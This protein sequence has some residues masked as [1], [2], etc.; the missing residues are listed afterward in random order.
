MPFTLIKTIPD[1]NNLLGGVRNKGKFAEGWCFEVQTMINS[2]GQLFQMTDKEPYPL[3]GIEKIWYICADT[4]KVK[5]QFMNVIIKL[6]LKL[7]H[8]LG[9]WYNSALPPKKETVA[10][11]VSNTP[12][13]VGNILDGYW[14]LLQD[15]STCSGYQYK[16]LMC[17]PPKPGG[18]AC[19]GEAMRKKKC[20]E[21]P[22]PNLGEEES[23][24]K[25]KMNP[26]VI[27][28]MPISVRP[29][30][31][32]KCHLKESDTIYTAFKPGVGI[33]EN[34]MKVPSRIVM[35][36][37]SISI[38]TD[39]DLA[40]ELGTYILD[41]S[42]LKTIE[43][44]TNCFILESGEAK[45]KL[46][47]M[48]T[49][50]NYSQFVEEWKYDFNLFKAQCRKSKDKVAIDGAD[51]NA[52]NNELNKKVQA[53][54]LDVMK[55]KTKKIQIKAKENPINKVEKMEET[56]MIAVKKELDID[57]LLEKEELERE[58]S[59]QDEL[60]ASITK[61]RQKDECLIKSIKEK[62]LEDQFNME[63]FE[64]DKEV[65]T[66][67]EHAKKDILQKRNQ[68]KIKILN[69]RRR[70][71]RKKKLLND[72]LSNMR[73]DMAGNL[74]NMNK[75]GDSSQ[76]FK[77]TPKNPEDTKK[78]SAYCDK[79]FASASPVQYKECISEDTFCFVCCS[80]EIGEA[81]VR[82]REQCN[83]KCDPP[84]ED[85]LPTKGSWQWVQ[86]TNKNT[87]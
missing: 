26:P 10:D 55:E 44:D 15:W 62:E 71:E 35:N 68:V 17:V 34:P 54:T 39:E 37:K 59:E 2:S 23:N 13:T 5:A 43:G 63:K 87:S 1:D 31:Y 11:M 16:Q 6:R 14:I 85:A 22:C 18:K 41:R 84:K 19:T 52:L 77:P 38:Y 42:S 50:G 36:E 49:S 81:H 82:D 76:C 47:N 69:M 24:K 28:M 3:K 80:T 46:C 30:R 58:S 20:N 56:A 29:L 75:M 48:D 78:I 64:K 67:K 21:E 79:N 33:E 12:Q 60:R 65:A 32:D 83:E 27:K 8:N 74:G 73:N 7:Q 53:A 72:Q 61:E 86:S 57:G 70:A 4:E 25:S 9:L 40:S 45:G 51:E 66:I